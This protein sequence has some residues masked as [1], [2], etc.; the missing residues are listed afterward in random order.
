MFYE[1]LGLFTYATGLPVKAECQNRQLKDVALE[2]LVL[3]LGLTTQPFL[4]LDQFCKSI[5]SS[6]SFKIR[7]AEDQPW[8]LSL[9]YLGLAVSVYDLGGENREYG[10]TAFSVDT[11]LMALPDTAEA[12]HILFG[13]GF[14]NARYGFIVSVAAD[15]LKEHLAER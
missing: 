12:G 1:Q 6:P 7:Q 15:H 9:E 3:T 5:F 10:R 13:R 11:E 14:L 8:N 4:S 2:V